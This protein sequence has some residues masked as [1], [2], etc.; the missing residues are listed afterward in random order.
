MPPPLPPSTGATDSEATVRAL[1][2]STR[3]TGDGGAGAE[4]AATSQPAL[5]T[6]EPVPQAQ[7]Q[8]SAPASLLPQHPDIARVTAASAGLQPGSKQPPRKPRKPKTPR[9]V[10]PYNFT[11]RKGKAPETQPVLETR[12]WNGKIG[13]PPAPLTPSHTP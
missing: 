6:P 9:V 2:S 4:T 13:C 12:Y 11:P 3:P 8:V 5:D 1:Y 10:G 7:A